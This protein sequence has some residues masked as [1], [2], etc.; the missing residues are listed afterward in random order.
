MKKTNNLILS[1]LMAGILVTGCGVSETQDK[2]NS[3]EK[4]VESSIIQEESK[5]VSATIKVVVAGKEMDNLELAVDNGV[6]LLDAMKENM[7][8]EETDG[9][10][11]SINGIEQS[12]K[13]NKFWVYTVNDEQVTVGA[14]EYELSDGDQVVWELTEF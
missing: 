13:E 7:E 10:I 14:G 8:I 2:T 9:F 5:E 12:E 1:L 3:S 4:Q 11:N 6:I